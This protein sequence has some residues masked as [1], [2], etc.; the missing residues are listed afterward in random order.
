MF[1]FARSAAPAAEVS[2][3]ASAHWKATAAPRSA[4]PC[5]SSAKR[6]RWQSVSTFRTAAADPRADYRHRAT[7][8]VP[9][10]L[11]GAAERPVVQIVD[12]TAAR[13]VTA[14]V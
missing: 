2:A 14:A 6:A 3:E 1:H 9:A 7:F 5:E 13:A 12:P 8:A 4:N 11:F 10:R